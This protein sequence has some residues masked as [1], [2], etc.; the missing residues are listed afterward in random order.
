[1]NLFSKKQ[2]EMPSD[3]R[4]AQSNSFVFFCIK[5]ILPYGVR[6]WA[7]GRFILQWSGGFWNAGFLFWGHLRQLRELPGPGCLFEASWWGLGCNRSTGTLWVFF[8][9]MGRFNSAPGLMAANASHLSQR[10]KWILAQELA[11]L[12]ERALNYVWRGKEMKWGSMKMILGEQCQGWGEGNGATEVQL[13]QY[14]QHGQQMG[15]HT[16]CIWRS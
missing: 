12:V 11:G 1:M 3:F 5:G 14:R 4:K 9:I 2:L 8:L 10:G 6:R 16:E 7:L 15:S 13:H